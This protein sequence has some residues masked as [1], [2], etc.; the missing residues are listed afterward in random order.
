[1]LTFRKTYFLLF[2]LLLI[3]EVL[4]ALFIHDRFIRPYAGDYLVV[5]MLY[6]FVRAFVKTPVLPAALAV[7]LFSYF[8]EVLQYFQVVSLIGLDDNEVARTIIGYQ[9]EW[10]DILAYTLGIITVLLVEKIRK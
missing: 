2:L 8:I 10:I 6:C 1:M 5:I 9:F 3:V 4:I 7:L